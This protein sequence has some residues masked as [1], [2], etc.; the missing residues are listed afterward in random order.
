M[1]GLVTPIRAYAECLQSD[2][3]A[4]E[5]CHKDP[6]AADLVRDR[7]VGHFRREIMLP[8]LIPV[9]PNEIAD[10]SASGRWR[11]V[12]KLARALRGERARGRAGH[13]TFSLNRHIGLLQAFRAETAALRALYPREVEAQRRGRRAGEPTG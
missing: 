8:R 7:D 13:W 1:D 2:D 11:L 3:S 6:G 5:L 10:R 9:G 4:P 12:R